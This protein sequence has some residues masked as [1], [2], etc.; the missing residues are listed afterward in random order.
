[1]SLPVLRN[2]SNWE[3]AR[4]PAATTAMGSN[5]KETTNVCVRVGGWVCWSFVVAASFEV[6]SATAYNDTVAYS[7]TLDIF[8]ARFRAGPPYDKKL[9]VTFAPDIA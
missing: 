4:K 3:A 5:N 2:Q 8:G 7:S 9:I 6:F 1:M